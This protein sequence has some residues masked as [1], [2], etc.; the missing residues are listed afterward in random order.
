MKDVRTRIRDYFDQVVS[1]SVSD[2]DDIFA[3]GLVN[4][5]F[6][7]Q[8]VMFVEKEFSIIVEKQELDIRHFSSIS[9]LVTFVEGKLQLASRESGHGSA[10][11]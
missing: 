1:D 11:D 8:L 7:L 5:L 4:S 10:A 9:A 2:E 6:G 3:L